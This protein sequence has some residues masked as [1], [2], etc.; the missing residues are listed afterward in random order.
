MITC[1][2]DITL[3][4]QLNLWLRT[5]NRVYVIAQT[6]QVNTFEDLFQMTKSVNWKQYVPNHAPIYLD[7]VTHKNLLTS[8]PAIQK[9]VKKAMVESII[10]PR[11]TILPEDENIP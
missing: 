11:G 3:L 6:G 5:A 4:I 10:G 7:T 8:E 2:G 9:T 1:E